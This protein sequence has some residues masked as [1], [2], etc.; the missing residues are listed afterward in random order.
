MVSI[1]ISIIQHEQHYLIILLISLKAGTLLNKRLWRRCF[2]VNFAKFL[3]TTFFVEHI[4]AT[5][6]GLSFTNPRKK[7]MKEL[8]Y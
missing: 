6:F 3:G 8:V 2:P 4:Q 1:L 7:S 5:A